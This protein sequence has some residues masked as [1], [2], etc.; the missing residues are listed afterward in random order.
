MTA[1][2]VAAVAHTPEQAQAVA[3]ASAAVTHHMT[4]I[5]IAIGTVAMT[6]TATVIVTAATAVTVTAIVGEALWPAAF[7]SG[8]GVL[9]QRIQVSLRILAVRRIFPLTKQLRPVLSKLR[10]GASGPGHPTRVRTNA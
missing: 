6:V 4:V 2:T 5:V 7:Y 10:A 3:T 9:R 1:T 8:S